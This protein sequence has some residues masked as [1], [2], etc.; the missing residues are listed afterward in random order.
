ME[1]DRWLLGRL[2]RSRRRSRRELFGA[3]SDAQRADSAAAE[4]GRLETTVSRFCHLMVT[5]L[6]QTQVS[7]V[8]GFRVPTNQRRTQ[9]LVRSQIPRQLRR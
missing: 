7:L 3:L 5:A 2:S 9:P 6:L 8:E 4:G 1:R